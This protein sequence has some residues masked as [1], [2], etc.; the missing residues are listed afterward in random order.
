MAVFLNCKN[1]S[2]LLLILL[3][4]ISLNSAFCDLL[5]EELFEAAGDGD[6]AKFKT[7]IE[8]GADVQ[9]QN[10][11]GQTVLMI[12]A[13][14]GHPGLARFLILK[15]V[16][17][18]ALDLE[19][20]SALIY[21]ARAGHKEMVELLIG[22]GA[23]VHEKGGG[24]YFA[25]RDGGHRTVAYLIIDTMLE[26]TSSELDTIES[27]LEEGVYVF[28]GTELEPKMIDRLNREELFLLLS[29][30]YAKYDYIFE[31]DE[32]SAH[33]SRFAWYDAKHHSVEQ[34]FTQWER[35]LADYILWIDGKM[36]LIPPAKERLE[37]LLS[38][39]WGAG[40]PYYPSFIFDP[41]GTFRWT[42]PDRTTSEGV[43]G[44]WK[45]VGTDVYVLL[46][47]AFRQSILTDEIEE[48]A[49]DSARWER[50]GTFSTYRPKLKSRPP[51]MELKSYD[52]YKTQ[53][54]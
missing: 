3:L 22:Y 24:A 13:Q 35:E 30:V 50:I 2:I 6:I 42:V 52:Y 19:G 32:L 48:E 12:A 23:D 15:G 45:L 16:P 34:Y 36:G 4:S 25:A 43:K 21:A 18:N 49:V 26:G 28:I 20:N 38:G 41:D 39:E 7:L 14:N 11:V 31:A 33:F 1:R 37:S 10:A 46:E 27:I 8:R 29:T 40:P 53:D 5:D 47:S 9:S 17:V 54:F 51:I 44:C